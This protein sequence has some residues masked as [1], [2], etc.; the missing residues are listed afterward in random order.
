MFNMNLNMFLFFLLYLLI[1]VSLIIIWL[2][3]NKKY[4]RNGSWKYFL[5]FSFLT[6]FWCVLY[7]FSYSSTYDKNILLYISRTLYSLTIPA[8]YS[9]IIFFLTFNNRNKV[10]ILKS[11]FLIILLFIFIIVFSIFTPYVIEDLV[12]D[13]NNL[14]YYEKYWK[15]YYVYSALYLLVLPL[16]LIISWYRVKMLNTIN[17][18]RF[19]IMWVWF[20]IFLLISIIFLVVLPSLG[21]FLL[22][23]EIVFFFIPFILASRYSIYKYYYIDI[24]I[25]LSIIITFLISLISSVSLTVLIFKLFVYYLNNINTSLLKI[26]HQWTDISQND[27]IIF[28]ILNLVLFKVFYFPLKKRIIWKAWNNSFSKELWKLKNE[29]PFISSLQDL[30]SFIKNKFLNLYKIKYSEIIIFND[31]NSYIEIKNYFRKENLNDILINDIVFI[32]ENKNKFDKEKILLGLDEDV[33]IILPLFIKNF[34][35]I[36]LFCIWKKILNDI[37]YKEEI[38]AL[39]DLVDFIIG[40]LK[41]L[42]IYDRINDLNINL[43]KRIDEKTMQYN[44]LINK[45]KD[46]ISLISHEIKWPIGSSVFQVDWLLD[47]IEDWKYD[48]SFLKKELGLLIEQL[49]KIW[50]LTNKLFSIE[51][52]DIWKIEL[53]KEKININTLILNEFEIIKRKNNKVKFNF[54][55]SEDIWFT[56]LDKVQIIQVIENLINNA[57]KFSSESNNYPKIIITTKCDERYITIEIEDNWKEFEY[58][59]ISGLFEKYTTWK[60]SSIWLG[61]W[62]YL[63]KKIIS[64]HNWEIS[65]IHSDKLWWAKFI[66]KLPK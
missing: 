59:N 36:W 48:E 1:A 57:I 64:L 8:F 22:Q 28:F 39:K 53:L 24:K 43:D 17:K 5:A 52:Y 38:L 40:H 21:I 55:L 12:I 14:I 61:M 45:Q 65:A 7:F 44:T 46:F 66:I 13:S 42:R 2:I 62:L 19:K 10:K 34:E 3:V 23:K 54:N 4:N 32:E 18:I 63:C 49:L 26:W 15:L 27:M 47:D 51:K 60:W 56:E 30:N 50:N 33:Y 41:Y 25:G 31:L 20:T 29:I 35:L 16:F 6:S 58:T 9:V 11:D 37:Y